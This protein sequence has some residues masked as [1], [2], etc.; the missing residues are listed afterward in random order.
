V[1]NPSKIADTL[2]FSCKSVIID[3]QPINYYRYSIEDKYYYLFD[4]NIL[5]KSTYGK[6]LKNAIILGCVNNG[7]CFVLVDIIKNKIWDSNGGYSLLKGNSITDR[8]LTNNGIIT[9]YR[10]IY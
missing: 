1:Y 6:D 10:I 4:K 2:F 5:Q 9:S 7:E 8:N 3:G